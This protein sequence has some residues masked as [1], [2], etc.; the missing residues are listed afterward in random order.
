VQTLLRRLLLLLLWD[1]VGVQQRR[2]QWWQRQWAARA[3]GM[4]LLS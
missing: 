3:S 2:L 4:V 1:K